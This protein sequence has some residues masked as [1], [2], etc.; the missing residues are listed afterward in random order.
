MSR[1][2][3]IIFCINRIIRYCS[4]RT[5]RILLLVD[6]FDPCPGVSFQLPAD[7]GE[8]FFR[9]PLPVLHLFHNAYRLTRPVGAGRIARKF[10][11]RHIRVMYSSKYLCSKGILEKL[12]FSIS[13][14]VY[15]IS[16]AIISMLP[17]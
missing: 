1:T 7:P 5:A 10:L 12:L 2:F 9:K 4:A 16:Y 14:F 15:F 6:R 17:L 11:I 8:H 3:D 13:A